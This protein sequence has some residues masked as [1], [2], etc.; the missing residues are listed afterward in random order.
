MVLAALVIDVSG[1][2]ARKMEGEAPSEP[3]SGS[4]SLGSNLHCSDIAPVRATRSA[5]LAMLLR[6]T[7]VGAPQ[8]SLR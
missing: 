8:S 1:G 2:V 5:D 7:S 6:L 4:D 3:R